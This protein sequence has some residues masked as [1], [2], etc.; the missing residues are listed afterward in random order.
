MASVIIFLIWRWITNVAI[1]LG[2]EFN[3]EMQHARAIEAGEATE[4]SDFAVPRDT[5]KLDDDAKAKAT[6][7]SE[8]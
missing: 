3:A 5:R 1:L 6:A 8:K 2:A 7:L 4:D